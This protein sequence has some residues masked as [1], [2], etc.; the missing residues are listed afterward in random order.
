M[1]QRIREGLIPGKM[2][3][4]GP[5]EVDEAYFGGKEKNKHES[6]RLNSGRG[7]VGKTAV[8]GMKDRETKQVQTRVV[9][10]ITSGT[11]QGIISDRTHASVTLY[12]DDFQGYSGAECATRAS[13]KH[14]VKEYVRGQAHISG[15]ESFWAVLRRTYHGVYHK[16]SKKH[17][18]AYI[19]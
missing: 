3:F 17:L 5:V 15:M 2:L 8:V 1:L 9:Q 4:D 11:L 18:N 19:G 16:I 12:T 13:V 14:S 6:K 10:D 7:T